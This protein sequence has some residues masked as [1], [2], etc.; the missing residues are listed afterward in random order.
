M[1]S[2]R[3]SF[4]LLLLL[5]LMVSTLFL[6]LFDIGPFS[7]KNY[8]VTVLIIL[9][10][11]SIVVNKQNL[12]VAKEAYNLF[13]IYSGFIL[14]VFIDEIINGKSLNSVCYNLISNHISGIAIFIAIQYYLRSY[15]D[16]AIVAAFMGITVL[17]SVCVGIMQYYDVPLAWT[18]RSF[19]Y[20]ERQLLL[21]LDITDIKDVGYVPGLSLYSIN[22]TYH[23]ATFGMILVAWTYF[24]FQKRDLLRLIVGMAAVSVLIVG[25]LLGQSRSAFF[26][27]FLGLFLLIRYAKDDHADVFIRAKKKRKKVCFFWVN[28]NNCGFSIF[29]C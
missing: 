27:V 17:L 29:P 19:L 26:G 23:I 8:L 11:G 10:I 16:I 24:V 20:P 6:N 5:T 2:L 18:L 9:L 25:L 14:W 28:Y 22:F 4:P 7:P 13:L 3:R 21:A 1:V 15:R 12:F